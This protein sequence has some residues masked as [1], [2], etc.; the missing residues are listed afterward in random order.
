MTLAYTYQINNAHS[1][2]AA[3][4]SALLYA[5]LSI[6][7]NLALQGSCFFS[8]K[9]QLL[10]LFH[11]SIMKRTGETSSILSMGRSIKNNVP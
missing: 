8:T 5:K 9:S 4:I 3:L 6:V 1:F 7:E 11:E 10:H 2:D